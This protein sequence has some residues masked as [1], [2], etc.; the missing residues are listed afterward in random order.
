MVL[1][2]SSVW[3]EVTRKKGDLFAK[4]SLR[5]LL[6]EYQ[7][8]FCGPVKLE[9]MGAVNKELRRA[10]SL[11]FQTVPYLPMQD[12]IWEEAKKITWRLRDSGVTVPWNDVVI[13]AIAL[14]K[15]CRVYSL[16]KHFEEISRIT[17]MRLYLPGDNGTYNPDSE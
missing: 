9:V 14:E 5:C 4:A 15:N 16:D 13:A 12:Q 6:E 17:R 1:V 3:I 8:A 10:T 2:D 7:A 11:L